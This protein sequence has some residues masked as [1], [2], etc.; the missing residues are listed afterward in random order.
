MQP[1]NPEDPKQIGPFTL[2]GR[3]GSGGM[4]VVFLATR[5][6]ET[7]ALKVVRASF[8]DDKSLRTRFGREVELLRTIKSPFIAQVVDANTENN[9]AYLAVEFI[10]GP[11]L[12]K[13]VE[14]KG[15]LSQENWFVLA[16]GLLRALDS[17]HK[18]KIIH[19]DIKPSNIL[20]SE[21]GPKLIDFGIAQ[22]TDATSL[23]STGLVA[24]SPAWLSPEQIHGTPLT[25]AT[26]LF[27]AGSVLK[28]AASGISPWGDQTSTTTPVVFNRILNQD[29][30]LSSLTDKQKQL[31]SKLLEK[32]PQKRINTTQALTL[33]KEIQGN[34]IT[35]IFTESFNTKEAK[36]GEAQ[37]ETPTASYK[38]KM[39]LIASVITGLLLAIS[40]IAFGTS[41]VDTENQTAATAEVEVSQTP[42]QVPTA[43]VEVSQSPSPTAEVSEAIVEEEVNQLEINFLNIK[44]TGFEDNENVERILLS[45][46]LQKL[47]NLD[48]VVGIC[49]FPYEVAARRNEGKTIQFQTLENGN[50]ITIYATSRE[51]GWS[52]YSK[53]ENCGGDEEEWEFYD[54][55]FISI[56]EKLVGECKKYR[57]VGPAT[58]EWLRT[59]REWCVAVS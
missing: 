13:R 45:E 28:F 19:R 57:I 12:K 14:D 25:F 52:K 31:V 1:L 46:D 50:W 39:P 32:D 23:T 35:P 42:T 15:P 26:D 53:Y 37:L 43:E 56:A 22:I 38:T 33:L 48:W 16:E 20:L 34:Q 47:S 4:G 51:N 11:D 24:G 36:E 55:N 44:A 5:E 6:S 40:L 17:I 58:T 30:D 27:S 18:A 29:P 10:N 9:P 41:G 7:V 59:T 8:L 2:I 21:S 3:L 54:P 49:M